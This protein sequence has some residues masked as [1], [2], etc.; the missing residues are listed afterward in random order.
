LKD[1]F[2]ES[3]LNDS[4]SEKEANT[5]PKLDDILA[6]SPN[7]NSND[8]QRSSPP[9]KKNNVISIDDDQTTIDFINDLKNSDSYREKEKSNKNNEHSP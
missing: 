1:I 7:R 4:N 3:D 2:K 9:E 6:K 8:L 5:I